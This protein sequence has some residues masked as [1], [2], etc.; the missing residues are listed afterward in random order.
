MSGREFRFLRKQMSL[1]QAELAECLGVTDQTVA[2]ITKKGRSRILA[3]P[4][5]EGSQNIARR[6]ASAAY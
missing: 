2:T 3:L 5:S 6:T 1:T 4:R